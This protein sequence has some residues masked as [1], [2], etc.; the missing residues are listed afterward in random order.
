MEFL[1]QECAFWELWREI[2]FLTNRHALDCNGMMFVTVMA[3]KYDGL[4]SGIFLA[5]QQR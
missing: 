1:C 2:F 5:L 3:A 4:R